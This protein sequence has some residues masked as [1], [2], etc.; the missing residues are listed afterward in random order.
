MVIISILKIGQ[1]WREKVRVVHLH[2]KVDKTLKNISK[3][4]NKGIFKIKQTKILLDLRYLWELEIKNCE[5]F[6]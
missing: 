6:N 1:I 5:L 2:S 3:M 4:A